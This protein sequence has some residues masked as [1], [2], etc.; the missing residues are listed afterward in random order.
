MTAKYWIIR[1]GLGEQYRINACPGHE[2]EQ[3]KV[4]H[5]HSEHDPYIWTKLMDPLAQIRD[6]LFP[7]AKQ[8]EDGSHLIVNTPAE[9]LFYLAEEIASDVDAHWLEGLDDVYRRL[10]LVEEILKAAG[11]DT[12]TVRGSVEPASQR[13]DRD[14]EASDP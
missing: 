5:I 3:L 7:K 4:G 11:H 9:T 1:D 8:L 2:I 12:A 10:K 6:I 13:A 14:G